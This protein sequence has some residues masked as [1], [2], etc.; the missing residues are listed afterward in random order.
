MV[1][2]EGEMVENSEEERKRSR[3][4]SLKKMAIRVS[5]IFTHSLKK[6]GKRKIDFR[7]P[8]EDVR[9]AQE[10][11]AVQELHQRLLQRGLVPP[12]HDDYHAFLLSLFL[13]ILICFLITFFFVWYNQGGVCLLSHP[14]VIFLVII[15]CLSG[16]PTQI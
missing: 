8:I 2:D 7:I 4:G 11:F 13:L 15:L 3:I 1:E 12:R 6:R 9:D 14:C 5:S 10:E 16:D